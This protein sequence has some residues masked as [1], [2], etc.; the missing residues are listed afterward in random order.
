MRSKSWFIPLLILIFYGVTHIVSLTLLPVFA[1][2]AIYTRW[3]Q[4]IIDDPGRYAFFP[5]NDGKTPLFIWLLVPFQYL[6][7]DQLFA[8]RFVAVLV[9]ALQVIATG[10]L[11][12]ALGGKEKTAWLAMVLVSVLPFWFFHHRMVLM[13]GLLTLWLTTMMI[14]L[15]KLNTTVAAAPAKSKKILQRLPWLWIAVTGVSL[16][17]ALLTKL[18]AL[19]FLP[20][21]IVFGLWQPLS[22]QKRARLLSFIAAAGLLGVAIFASLKLTPVF[23]QL[24]SRGSDFLYP[25]REVLLGGVWQQTIQNWPT[26]ISYFLSYMTAPVM[27]L[28]L[29]GLFLKPSQRTNHILFWS[30]MGFLLPIAIL[31]RVVYPRYLMP[32]AIYFTLIA[33]FALQDIVGRWVSQQSDLVKK[34]LVAIVAVSLL[35]NILSVSGVFMAYSLANADETPFVSA[36]RTQYL[37]EWSSGHGLWE[38]AGLI[39][40]AAEDTTIA[41]ATEGYFGTLPDGLV[42]YFHRRDVDNI[43]IEGI[44]QPVRQIPESF[45]ERAR[46][47][48]R[49]WL[50]V[51]SHR[52]D[53]DLPSTNLIQEHCRPYAAP[54]LQIWDITD[55]VHQE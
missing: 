35:G 22:V 30:A 12:R 47:Y 4:L 8:G 3:A 25:W 18:P 42:M 45:L 23:G 9:G 37:T 51:N 13:D 33:A 41:V 50:V 44:G 43:Y 48:D 32:A 49:A 29:I 24:F 15:V 28:V 2:E 6:F 11:A 20:T 34:I 10:Y 54:C 40:H 19:L 52:L 39:R 55:L 27:L 5:L 16:G 1:D 21:M 7:A 53:L 26:Y 14:G 46:V 31:G 36:D 17:A 38:T